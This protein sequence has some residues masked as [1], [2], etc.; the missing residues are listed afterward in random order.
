MTANAKPTLIAMDMEGVFT[1]EIWIAVAEKTG[2]E[3]LRL[4]TRDIPDYD[5]LMRG[6][7]QLLRENGLKLSDIQSVIATLDPLPGAIEFT[8]WMREQA[9]LI[10]LTDSFAQFIEPLKAKLGHPTIFC[11]TLVVDDEN[12]VVDYRLRQVNGKK[13]AVAAFNSLGF[14]VIAMGDSY[15]DTAMLLEAEHGILFRP[16]DNVKAEFPQFPA[17]TEYVDVKAKLRELL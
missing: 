17:L 1:P 15:N 16:S 6:R 4:T 12:N 8:N 10:I 9:P 14:R 3:K 13:Q 11:N 2:V 7:L 5:Q